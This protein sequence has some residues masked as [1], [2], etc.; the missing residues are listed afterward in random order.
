MPGTLQAQLCASLIQ[1]VLTSLANR[2]RLSHLNKKPAT[3]R[4]ENKELQECFAKREKTALMQKVEASQHDIKMCSMK[5]AR[6]VSKVST[7]YP[8]KL[9]IF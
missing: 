2:R 3:A 4:L 9:Y 1:K 7:L 6:V 8:H 5:G